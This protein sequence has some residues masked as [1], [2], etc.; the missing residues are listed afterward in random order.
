MHCRPR[1]ELAPAILDRILVV[2]D[3]DSA[4]QAMAMLLEFEGF[5]VRTAAGGNAAL[6]IVEHWL[7]DLVVS[8]VQMPGGD[9]FQL[10]SALRQVDGCRDAPIL[11]VSARDEI[12]RRINGLDL[13]ADDFMSK[14]LQPEELLAR[15]RA[16]LRSSHRRKALEQACTIDD[17]TKLLNRR[18][19]DEAL[20]AEYERAKRGGSFCALLIDLDGFKVINDSH[21]HAVG[22]EVLHKVAQSIEGTRR[23]VDR[24]GRWGGDEFVVV[25]SN[26]TKQQEAG[27]ISRFRHAI[28]REVQTSA[29]ATIQIRCSIGAASYEEGLSLDG[30]MARA[31]QS[32]YADKAKR[33]AH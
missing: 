29:G 3:D 27:T 26:C 4:R 16:H 8:D 7:P 30:I 25:L 24:A 22:D 14:P 31:D 18:G 12:D 15:I 23:A 9:G 21:G 2:E 6:A 32:M 11:L 17:L 33:R 28:E 5:E 1:M 20:A 13:G 10:V 19:L